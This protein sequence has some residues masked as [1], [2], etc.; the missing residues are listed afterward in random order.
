MTAAGETKDNGYLYLQHVDLIEFLK[1][2]KEHQP[3]VREELETP[4]SLIVEAADESIGYINER[5]GKLNTMM[6][7]LADMFTRTSAFSTR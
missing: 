1:Q 2:I 3:Q 6:G 7:Q 4:M 5:L